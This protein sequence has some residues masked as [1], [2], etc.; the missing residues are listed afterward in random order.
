MI[1]SMTGFSR[2]TKHLQIGTVTV[3]LRSTNHRYLEV[4]QRMPDGLGALEGLVTE[5]VKEHLQRGRI[6]VLVSLQAPKATTKRVV[7]DEALAQAYLERLLE[8]KG[9]FGLK[10]NVT[11]DHLLT[12]PHLISVVDDPRQR[13]ALEPALHEVL[14]TAVRELVAMRRREG[15]RLLADIRKHVRLIQ[16]RAAA[17]YKRLPRSIAE[18]QQRLRSRIK[19]M[20]SNGSSATSAQIQEAIALLKDVDI[21]EELIRLESH[22]VHLQHILGSNGPI[23]K[24]L[25]FI[26]Q[27]LTREVNTIGA[28]A[29]DAQIARRVIEMKEAIEKIREQ[30]Q[31]LE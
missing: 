2:T 20:L 19:Q 27:E 30:A 16:Q 31:N 21:H 26:A 13:Q 9:R 11:L 8:L 4:G 23:G 6:D 3:E 22:G 14:R 15:Q 7:F 17:I 25:D 12:L 24:K 28:K 18:Q 1:Q 29:N 10:G 5:L